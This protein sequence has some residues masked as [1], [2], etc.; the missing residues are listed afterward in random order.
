M[1]YMTQEMKKELSP[2]IKAVLKKNNLKGS[3]SVRHH[4]TLVVTISSGA[5]DFENQLDDG[6]YW[7]RD[8]KVPNAAYKAIVS[9]LKEVM[10]VGN[11]DNSDI[12]T[13]YFDVGFYTDVQVGKWNKPYVYTG[14]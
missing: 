6:Q 1:A 11:H 12:M 13:D 7:N 14:A 9:E 8:S 2:A 3:V 5:F 4:S 10:N